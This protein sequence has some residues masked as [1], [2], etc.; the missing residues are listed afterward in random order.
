VAGLAAAA[1]MAFYPPAVAMTAGFLSEPL[2][3][4]T[5]ALAALVLAWAW[6]GEGEGRFALAGMALGLACLAR[7]DTLPAALVLPPAVA[8]ALWRPAGPAGALWRGG[9]LAAGTAAVLAPWVAHAS[10]QAGHLVPVTEGSSSALYIAT[11]LEGGGTLFG[12]KRALHPEACR[13]HPAICHRPVR[14]IRAEYLLDAVA[15]RHPGLSRD[16]ALRREALR[17]LAEARRRPGAFAEMLAM[18]AGRLWGGYFRGRDVPADPAVLWGHR[19]LVLAATAGLLAGIAR[20]RSAL[21]L[22]LLVG[23]LACSALNVVFVAEARHNAR[24]LPVL[25]AAGAAGWAL[26]VSRA[27]GRDTA[28]PPG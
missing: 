15:A 8:V 10:T 11:S 28:P 18:K 5:L 23:L 4:C 25:V 2:G 12:A 22:V 16:A 19:A 3:A 13:I 6:R 14:S 7:A 27:P 24:L 26:A 9:L 20:S 1:I 17:N 21:L